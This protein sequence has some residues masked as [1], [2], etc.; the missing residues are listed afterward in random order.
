MAQ[1]AHPHA[2]L[3]L[4]TALDISN[5]GI[6]SDAVVTKASW[7]SQALAWTAAM[8]LMNS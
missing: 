7:C 4:M 2:L 5:T 1:T 3:D 6:L 8:H